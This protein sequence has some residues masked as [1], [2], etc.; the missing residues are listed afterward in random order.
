DATLLNQPFSV[1]GVNAGDRRAHGLD[2]LSD[3]MVM[4]PLGMV[5][6]RYQTPLR[7]FRE[8]R[9]A[10]LEMVAQAGEQDE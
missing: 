7:M 5:T 6:P 1:S 9:E 10:I 4:T 3:W 8:N 2:D